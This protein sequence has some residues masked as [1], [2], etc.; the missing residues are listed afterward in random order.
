MRPGDELGLP[1]LRER[2]LKTSVGSAWF[3]RRSAQVA[4]VVEREDVYVSPRRT[5]PLVVLGSGER[6]LVVDRSSDAKSAPAV[7]ADGVLL[8]RGDRPSTW[9]R[10]KLLDD[11]L[12]RWDEDMD[13]V[14]RTARDEWRRSFRISA[15]PSEEGSLALRSP[16]YGALC[17]IAA[18]W[19]VSAAPATV[20][21]PTGT[22]KTETMLAAFAGIASGT[23]LVV[24]PSKSL[25]RQTAE[26]FASLGLL[27]ELGVVAGDVPNPVVG[28][29]TRRPKDADDLTLF[30]HCDVVVAVVNSVAQGTAEAL[31]PQVAERCST[32]M[33]D[34][35]HHAPAPTW[36][37]L[38]E[39]F[40][41]KPV[42]QFTDFCSSPPATRTSGA[43]S[44]PQPSGRMCSS[45]RVTRCSGR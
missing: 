38:R 5:A 21:M 20:V 10:H 24:V 26:K 16:Q 6:V 14:R 4:Q 7:A 18:H 31:L 17:A 19:T 1:V 39:H 42:L 29:L 15:R 8:V 22:G 23:T 9:L 44:S 40:D 34:E 28:V 45:S 41:G 36:E 32:L 43:A 35:A 30:A 13:G 37:G 2:L 33:L 25:R 27:R 12:R 3:T 11:F